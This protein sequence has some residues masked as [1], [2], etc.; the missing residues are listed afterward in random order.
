MT[1]YCSDETPLMNKGGG[2]FHTKSLVITQL[3]LLVL[4]LLTRENQ[5]HSQ[6]PNLP[7]TST[8]GWH[9]A[10]A[11]IVKCQ[12]YTAHAGTG[13]LLCILISQWRSV[14]GTALVFSPVIWVTERDLSSMPLQIVSSFYF[15]K[16]HVTSVLLLCMWRC[17]DM[18]WSV[19][20]KQE[21]QYLNNA[22]R[23]QTIYTVIIIF[24]ALLAIYHKSVWNKMFLIH[25]ALLFNAFVVVFNCAGIFWIL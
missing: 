14:W 9:L 13:H 21:K 20:I 3:K 17:L 8:E 24:S 5:D 16:L 1:F 6:R 15:V 23:I 2:W 7:R 18:C 12:N 25:T 11:L 4:T 19:C 10:P 22:L